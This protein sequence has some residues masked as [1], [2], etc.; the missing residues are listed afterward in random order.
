[1][2]DITNNLTRPAVLAIMLAA[3]PL[4]FGWYQ[5]R[6]K[7]RLDERATYYKD[8]RAELDE[9]RARLDAFEFYAAELEGYVIALEAAM[10]K[11]G[12][13]L[14]PSGRPKRPRRSE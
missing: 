4:L 6:D 13:S 1:M 7:A 8:I 9:L 2:D 11:A 14:P 10:L 3:L 12:L 5:A